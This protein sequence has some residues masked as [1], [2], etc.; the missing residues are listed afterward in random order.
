VLAQLAG[1]RAVVATL[2]QTPDKETTTRMTAFFDHLAP[3][4]G[5]AEAIR[6][7]Q[8]QI[9]KQRRARGKAAHPFSWAA[10]TQTGPGR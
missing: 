10:F 7:A 5:Q 1:A 8:L 6:P 2:W 4:K 3:R 9:I